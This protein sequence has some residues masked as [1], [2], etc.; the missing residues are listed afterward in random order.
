MCDVQL[1]VPSLARRLFDR[2]LSLPSNT[3]LDLL[4]S[5][6]VSAQPIARERCS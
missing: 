2:C 5:I 1:A 4:P 6:Y 3:P